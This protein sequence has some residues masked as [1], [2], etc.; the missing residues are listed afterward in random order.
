MEEYIR[1]KGNLVSNDN[2]DLFVTYWELH[3]ES[4][5][6]Y[7]S[8]YI[9]SQLKRTR[10]NIETF[11]AHSVRSASN[12]TVKSVGVNLEDILK[13]GCWKGSSNFKN[14]YRS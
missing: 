1:R 5:E 12:I 6:D 4:S 14:H 10:V 11:K 2:K 9:K 8:R 7:I 13:R 3:K